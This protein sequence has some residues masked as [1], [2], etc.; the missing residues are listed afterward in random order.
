MARSKI[1][2][3]NIGIGAKLAIAPAL[4]II[5]MSVMAL[6]GVLSIRAGSDALK[7]FATVHYERQR[8]VA[9]LVQ[10]LAEAEG[11]LYRMLSFRASSEDAQALKTMAEQPLAAMREALSITEQLSA[12]DLDPEQARVAATLKKAVETYMADAAQVIKMTSV[13]LSTAFVF[14]SKVEKR[15]KEVSDAA[16]TVKDLGEAS[17]QNALHDADAHAALVDAGFISIFAAAVTLAFAVN[18]VLVRAIGPPAR[19]LA[20]KMRMLAEGDTTIVIPEEQRRDEIG[21]MASALATFRAKAIEANALMEARRQEQEQKEQ[22]RVRLESLARSFDERAMRNLADMSEAASMMTARAKEMTGTT[23]ATERLSEE[24]ANAARLASENVQTMASAATELSSS[25]QE[26]QRQVA[27]CA[28]ITERAVAEAD[29]S[30]LAVQRL[31]AASGKIENVARLISEI[32]GRTNLLALN[33]TIEAARA[34]DAGRGF[35]IVASEVKALANQTATATAEISTQIAGIHEATLLTTNATQQIRGTI[36]NVKEIAGSV[37]AAVEQQGAAT[38]EIARSAQQ[39]ASGTELAT[40]STA[41]VSTISKQARQSSQIV[42]ESS[43]A[44]V[45]ES[46]SLRSEVE[47]FLQGVKSA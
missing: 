37:A 8:T 25:V 23:E 6:I 21:A 28:E 9:R 36:A 11:G 34:G 12:S 20:A 31:T 46:E 13:D 32:A 15:F 35:A 18:W 41:E 17:G 19:A 39:A 16:K 3:G 5:L 26:I 10:D 7:A 14:M 4:V 43:S 42:I 38:Q 45:G 2:L 1:S 47:H 27:Q 24:A 40:K 44:L 22:R 30:G 29:A 33:A